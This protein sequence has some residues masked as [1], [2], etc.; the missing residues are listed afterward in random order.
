[1]ATS[2]FYILVS[3][4]CLWRARK[5]REKLSTDSRRSCERIGLKACDGVTSAPEKREAACGGVYMAVDQY[6]CF[7]KTPSSRGKKVSFV[8]LSR[9]HRHALLFAACA[10]ELLWL[11]QFL[12]ANTVVAVHLR[13]VRSVKCKQ[14][15]S[16][17]PAT[18]ACRRCAEPCNKLP[19]SFRRSFADPS[20][21]LLQNS[22]ANVID[23]HHSQHRQEINN[24]SVGAASL[25][26]Y[27]GAGSADM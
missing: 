5:H 17:A 25:P 9:L 8:N 14:S 18:C 23:L 13:A 15:L 19:L 10:K 6:S 12:L 1:M 2:R 7:R 16:F 20:R 26:I 22:P 24:A 11:L 3:P 27:K 21:N 4:N